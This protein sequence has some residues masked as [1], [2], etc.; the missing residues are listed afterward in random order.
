MFNFVA[1]SFS[2]VFL[3]PHE[4]KSFLSWMRSTNQVYIGDEYHLRLGIYLTNSRFVQAHNA[5]KSGFSVALNRFAAWT[6]SE[7][8]TLLG[9]RS[10]RPIAQ[11]SA[12]KP[13]S[14]D[15][16]DAIDWRTYKI[17]NAIKEQGPCGSCWAFGTIQAAESAYARKY[18]TL[19]SCSEQNLIDCVNTCYGC[20]GGFESA[21]YT[22]II[23]MQGGLLNLE[24]DYPYTARVGTCKYN[25]AKGLN[26]I[27]SF[28]RGR[29]GDEA[30]LKQLVGTVGVADVA[31]DAGHNSFQ[32]YSGGIYNE[33]ACSAQVLNHAVGCVGYGTQRSVDYWIVRNSWGTS[34]G[35]QGYIR[36][37][38]NK[39]NQCGIATDAL[40]PTA[41]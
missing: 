13:L 8:K 30:Y 7:Y 28:Q 32:L 3:A 22:Y 10:V 11:D 40:I 14:A 29:S 31:I 16:P 23:N 4:E 15:P 2:A 6:P 21:A 25:A 5:G 35:E 12:A 39:D 38:R 1:L 17:V 36:M 26:K 9:R 37:A 18:H 27:A 24:T 34:W 19:Y 20:S 41:A 33:M